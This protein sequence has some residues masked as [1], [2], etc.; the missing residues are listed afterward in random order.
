MTDALAQADIDYT[1]HQYTDISAHPTVGPM[2]I[3]RGD[4]VYVYDDHGNRYLEGLSG[5]WCSGLGFSEQ[6][7]VDAATRQ[8]QAMPYTHLFAHRSNEPAIELSKKLSELAPVA[9]MRPFFV[10]S[11]SEAIDVA[12]KMAWYYHR[13][14]GNPGKTK[15]VA[16]QRAYHGVTVAAGCL[17]RLPYAQ[18]G[19]H[20]PLEV[21]QLETPHHYRY[22]HAGESEQDFADRLVEEFRDLITREGADTISALFAEPVMGAGGVMLPPADYLFRMRELCREH[23]ILFVADEVI[24][25][26]GRTGRM[27]GCQHYGVEP[28]MITCAKQLSSGYLPIGATLVSAELYDVFVERSRELGVFGT[29]HTY[30]GHPVA[31]AVALET[32]K[33]YEDDRIIDKVNAS[34]PH[35]L[36]RLHDLGDKPLVGDARGIG[37]IG[38]IELVQDKSTGEQYPV[39]DKIATRLTTLCR[40][41]GVILR[42]L[43]GDCVGI[44]PPLIINEAQIDELFDVLSEAIDTLVAELG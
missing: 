15:L 21:L 32:L 17:T 1:F 23:D 13:G 35:F 2:T 28:D 6:R 24:N 8:M 14:R 30:G 26:F 18:N 4:G 40:D 33:I 12:I 22:A 37:L 5:L 10:N 16:R 3:T 41:K 38:A 25:G 29:G 9:G 39:G 27:W 34:A 20:L 43:P 7:L 36:E 11:G 42:P 19:W 31:A 44:C